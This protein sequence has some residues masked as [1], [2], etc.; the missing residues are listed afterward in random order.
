VHLNLTEFEPLTAGP[1]ARL[2]VNQHGQMSRANQT[3]RLHAERLRAVYQEVCAQ[4]ERVA[5]LRAGISHLDS[6]HHV[7]TMPAFFPVL[8]DVQRR[9][10]IRRVRLAKNFYSSDEP[11]RADLRLKKRAYNWALKSIYTTHT[12]DAFTE[13]LTYYRADA[14][15][16]RSVASI[17]LMV[18]PGAPYAADETA[19]LE[20]DW[21]TQRDLRVQLI[22][23]AELSSRGHVAPPRPLLSRDL[24]PCD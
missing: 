6:H 21:T 12:T 2:L 24:V 11:C 5:A 10:G 3:M 13:F 19:A 20:R 14:A 7:H 9:Y 15:R 16:Q 17:E 1:G 22:S 8:K 4:I 18:H 23:Y